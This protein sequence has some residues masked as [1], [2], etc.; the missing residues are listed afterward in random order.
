[1]WAI[2]WVYMLAKNFSSHFD[3]DLTCMFHKVVVS[4]HAWNPNYNFVTLGIGS[5][6]VT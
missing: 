6:A 5:V 1:M 2:V 4:L 3:I